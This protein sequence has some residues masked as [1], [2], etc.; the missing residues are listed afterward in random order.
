MRI[1]PY[2][3]SH[4]HVSPSASPARW[5]VISCSEHLFKLTPADGF[6]EAFQ[7]AKLV[8]FDAGVLVAKDDFAYCHLVVL[9]VVAQYEAI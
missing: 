4:H 2:N 9:A 8:N 3:R 7:H 5:P 6:V 1:A